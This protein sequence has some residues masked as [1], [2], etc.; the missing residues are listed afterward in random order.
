MQVLLNLCENLCS[1]VKL[2]RDCIET[3]INLLKVEGNMSQKMEVE[4]DFKTK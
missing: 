3:E 4:T 1:H 2:V